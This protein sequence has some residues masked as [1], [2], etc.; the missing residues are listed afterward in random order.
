MGKM[1]TNDLLERPTGFPFSFSL[2]Q[3]KIFSVMLRTVLFLNE[4]AKEFEVKKCRMKGR[5]LITRGENVL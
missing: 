5:L 2:R 4:A 3:G 1:K